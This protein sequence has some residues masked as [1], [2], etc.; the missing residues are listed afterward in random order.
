MYR[1]GQKVLV[2]E[3]LEDEK[4]YGGV[5]FYHGMSFYKGK[6]VT[7]SSVRS[8]S[9]AT[10][11]ERIANQGVETILDIEENHEG[12]IWSQEMIESI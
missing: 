1:V 2:K 8:L 11:I 6:E 3:N 7:I 5:M 10:P 12:Y 4:R 9:E